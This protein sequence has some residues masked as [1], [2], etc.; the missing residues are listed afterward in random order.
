MGSGKAPSVLPAH[1]PEGSVW[2]Q[3]VLEIFQLNGELI[4]AGDSLGSEVGLTA[5]RWQVI[6]AI[7]DGRLTVA[8]IGRRMGLTRQSVRRT[9][10]L[11]EGEKMVERVSNPDHRSAELVQL[12]SRGAQAYAAISRRQIDWANRCAGSLS[13]SALQTTLRT[14]RAVRGRVLP[15]ATAGRKKSG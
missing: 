11:L 13:L 7:T 9:V 4:A 2:T 3:I 8:Q 10:D 15:A 12:T 1:T 5:A 6:G 14:L